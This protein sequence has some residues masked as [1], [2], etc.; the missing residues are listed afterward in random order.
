MRKVNMSHG[1]GA[2]HYSVVLSKLQTL[3]NQHG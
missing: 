3:A 1:A 2:N